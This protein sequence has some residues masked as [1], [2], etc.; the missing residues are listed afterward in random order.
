M[1][2]VQLQVERREG[3]LASIKNTGIRKL[4]VIH[5]FDYF[6]W[7][8]LRWITVVGRKRVEHFL[9]P[10]PVLQHLR[11]RL[12]EITRHMRS[13]KTAVLR[14]SDNRVQSVT[15]FV[16]QSLD[17]LVRHQRRLV[18]CRRRKV[19]KQGDSWSLVFSIRQQFAA[20]DFELCEVIEFSFARKHIEIKHPERFARGGI[21]HHVKLEIFGPFVRCGDLLEFQT[22]NALL[23]IEHAVEHFLYREK[24][25]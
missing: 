2:I 17:L 3:E 9:V 6:R 18:S 16:E 20:D 25:D 1:L 13:G 21:G 4:G 19:A 5:F 10:D 12:H 15:E 7:N 23:N 22:N 11:R 8:F 24:Y 14:A